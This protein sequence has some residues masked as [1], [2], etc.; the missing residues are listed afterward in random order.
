[1]ARSILQV[2]GYALKIE[3]IIAK[4][5][6]AGISPDPVEFVRAPPTPYRARQRVW[7][8]YGHRA[9]RFSD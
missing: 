7:I 8:V 9:W 2:Q 5:M 6:A 3:H 1:M 4:G